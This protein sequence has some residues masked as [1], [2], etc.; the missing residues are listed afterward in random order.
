MRM[1]AVR[2]HIYEDTCSEDAYIRMHAVR[3][4]IYKDACS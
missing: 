2:T 4:H 3:T 1:H